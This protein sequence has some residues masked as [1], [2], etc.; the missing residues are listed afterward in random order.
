MANDDPT[1]LRMGFGY[2]QARAA[3]LKGIQAS[4]SPKQVNRIIEENK[5]ERDAVKLI[6]QTVKNDPDWAPFV[7]HWVREGL[8]A[9]QIYDSL[10]YAQAYARERHS[11][12]RKFHP[13]F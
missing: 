12:L 7:E 6:R 5:T 2:H 8:S 10:F 4:R 1:N 3:G 11:L 9:D 13:P